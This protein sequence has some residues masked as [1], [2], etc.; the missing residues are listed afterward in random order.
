MFGFPSCRGGYSSA[1]VCPCCRKS[2]PGAVVL[3]LYPT[4][5][6]TSYDESS[7]G[8]SSGGGITSSSCDHSHFN[9]QINSLKTLTEKLRDDIGDMEVMMEAHR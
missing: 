8:S 4:A 3:P 5:Y 9:A 7:Q 2:V 6:D 1:K